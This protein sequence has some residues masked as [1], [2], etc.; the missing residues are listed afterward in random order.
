MNKPTYEEML[1]ALKR[2]QSFLRHL[3]QFSSQTVAIE[4]LL[5]F[6]EISQ[7]IVNA[8][9]SHEAPSSQATSLMI[10]D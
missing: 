1:E 10:R 5:V 6:D 2:S 7:I 9:K 4:A 8:E 3:R